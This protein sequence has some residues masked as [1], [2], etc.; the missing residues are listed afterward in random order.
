MKRFTYLI[1]GLVISVGIIAALGAS[2]PKKL[3]IN[4]LFDWTGQWNYKSNNGQLSLL[5]TLKGMK[6][7]NTMDGIRWLMA[8]FM[9]GP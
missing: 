4:Q 3:F 1:I 6:V 5:Y 7:D 8:G 9:V 2:T